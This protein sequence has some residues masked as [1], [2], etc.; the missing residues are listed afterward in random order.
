MRSVPRVVYDSQH[1]YRNM[2]WELRTVTRSLTCLVAVLVDDPVGNR[3][4]EQWVE[5][6]RPAFSAVVATEMVGAAALGTA[7]NL[8]S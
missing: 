8:R 7:S 5:R 6:T 1:T 2:S 4:F 3:A